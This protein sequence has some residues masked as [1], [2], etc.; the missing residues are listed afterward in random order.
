M[1][2]VDNGLWLSVSELARQRNR[3]KGSM[4]RR[5]ARLEEQG[6]LTTRLDGKTKLVNAAEFDKAVGQAGDAIKEQAA[7]PA[8]DSGGLSA[9]QTKRTAY[10]AELA[11]LDLEERQGKLVPVADL[12]AAMVRCAEKLARL[13]D[14]IVGMSDDPAVRTQLRDKV[15]EFRQLLADEMKLTAKEAEDEQAGA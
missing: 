8:E 7:K 15:R 14:G 13:A 6:L 11:R 4:S 2:Q 5:V 10:L 1:Q 12:T 3:D 9:E